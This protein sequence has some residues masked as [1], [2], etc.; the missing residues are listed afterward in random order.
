MG[1]SGACRWQR[2]R[3][4]LCTIGLLTL[5]PAAGGAAVL[6]AT[7]AAQIQTHLTTAEG[8]G[9]ADEIRIAV[10]TYAPTSTYLYTAVASQSLTIS[11]GW[12]STCSSQRLDPAPEGHD[13]ARPVHGAPPVAIAVLDRLDRGGR[14]RSSDGNG[15]LWLGPH[16]ARLPGRHAG[17][18]GIVGPSQA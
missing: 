1:I 6:C 15:T 11:G 14:R 18:A 7:S 10:G 12:D 2:G 9:V 8:N 4:V 13:L 16:L 17:R 5:W 3:K